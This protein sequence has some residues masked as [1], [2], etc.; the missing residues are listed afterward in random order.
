MFRLQLYY[1]FVKSQADIA[2]CLGSAF[3]VS[4]HRPALRANLFHVGRPPYRKEY[5]KQP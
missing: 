4:I 1:N 3:D 2:T 5:T